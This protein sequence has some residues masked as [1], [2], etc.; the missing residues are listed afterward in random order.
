[1][2]APVDSPQFGDGYIMVCIMVIWLHVVEWQGNPS[3]VHCCVVKVTCS[4]KLVSGTVLHVVFCDGYNVLQLY[5]VRVC[6][7]KV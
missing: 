4:E 5:H 1:M 6:W 7:I 2:Q 3:V